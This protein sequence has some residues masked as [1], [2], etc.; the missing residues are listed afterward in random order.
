MFGIFKKKSELEKLQSKYENLMK[1]AYS[2]S[3]SDRKKSDEKTYEAE[4]VM[5]QL[6]ALKA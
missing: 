2:L 1:E 5:K 6:I 3:T 4:E